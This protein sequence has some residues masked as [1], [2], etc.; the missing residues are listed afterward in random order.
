V[1]GP[2][3]DSN[4]LEN[5]DLVPEPHKNFAVISKDEKSDLEIHEMRGK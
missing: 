3:V 4:P 1:A 2:L 5:L